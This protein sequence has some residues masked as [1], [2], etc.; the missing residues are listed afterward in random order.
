MNI[1]G[2]ELLKVSFV[3]HKQW[4]IGVSNLPV[5]GFL[6]CEDLKST[7]PEQ[8]SSRYACEVILIEIDGMLVTPEPR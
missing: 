1:L 6:S 4:D 8:T 2:S 7:V 3:L 5:I